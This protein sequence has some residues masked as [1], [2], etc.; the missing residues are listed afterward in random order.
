M[1]RVATELSAE[2]R[3]KTSFSLG[4]IA[5]G[6]LVVMT[7]LPALAQNTPPPVP[8]PAPPAAAATAAATPEVEENVK[9]GVIASSTKTGSFAAIDVQTSGSSPGDEANVISASIAQK[10]GNECVAIVTNNGAKTYSVSFQVVGT[11]ASGSKPLNSSYSA[12]LKPKQSVERLVSR[13]DKDLNLAVVLKSAK[14]LK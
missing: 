6:T 11:T 14:A 9:P 3:S 13:C 1:K 10:G 4:A 8:P 12:T 5:A 7:A 2:L